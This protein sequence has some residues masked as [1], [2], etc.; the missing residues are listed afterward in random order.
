MKQLLILLLAINTLSAQTS[1]FVQS[2]PYQSYVQWLNPIV[3]DTK[4]NLFI[5][6]QTGYM[7]DKSF[8][9]KY[10]SLGNEQWTKELKGYNAPY[11]LCTDQ[12]G[13]VYASLG[14]ISLTLDGIS[15]AN[16]TSGSNFI[17]KWDG[18]GNTQF[19]KNIQGGLRFNFTE[20]TN[21]HDEIIFT[22]SFTGQRYNG[23]D[24]VNLGNNII[25]KAGYQQMH[26]FIGKL[27]T[28]G[29]FKE[30]IQD[31]AGEEPL[32]SNNKQEYFLYGMNY[33]NRIIGKGTNTVSIGY[34]YFI[35]KYDSLFNLVW[36]KNTMSW[37]IAPDEYGNVYDVNQEN[38]KL[39]FRK[40]NPAGELIWKSDTV[41]FSDVYK[42]DLECG[43]NGDL[44]FSM[45]YVNSVKIGTY[46]VN[47]DNKW[48]TLLVKLDSSGV[49]QWATSSK[50][51]GSC[52][53][54]DITVVHGNAIYITGDISGTV[55]F[56]DQTTS[57]PNGGVFLAKIVD[58]NSNLTGIHENQ[59]KTSQF[60]IYP[61]P[62]SSIFQIKCQTDCVIQVLNSLGKT[63]LTDTFK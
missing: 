52:G 24:S 45:G 39:L 60:E 21:N 16:N 43:K 42:A 17:I 54:K 50:G 12:S 58:D 28:N 44:Y 48:K 59:A 63:I 53:T 15:Y 46:T 35:A 9:S 1:H 41:S 38:N 8:I 5:S 51:T 31:E 13:N 61:N 3:K 7:G 11:S 29:T 56:G 32:K 18:N 27:T 26:Y 6:G 20:L 47:G 33:S 4:G 62:S 14:V 10:D 49:L 40:F 25:L 2:K 37:C 22:G 36:A 23:I 34:G 30:L 57:Q 19:V 55:T